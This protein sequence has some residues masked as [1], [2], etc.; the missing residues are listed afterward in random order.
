[1]N[2]LRTRRFGGLLGFIVV[3]LVII[4]AYFLIKNEWDV[5]AAVQEI[6]GLLPKQ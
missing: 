4:L 1:M 3:V 5:Q 6:I 2:N